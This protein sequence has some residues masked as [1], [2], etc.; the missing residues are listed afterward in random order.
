MSVQTPS[1]SGIFPILLRHKLTILLSGTVLAGIAFGLSQTLPLNYT[2]EGSLIVDSRVI[3]ASD[4]QSNSAVVND[5]LT[6]VDVLLSVGLIRHS[7]QDLDLTHTPGIVATMRLPPPIARFVGA[8]RQSFI[9]LW[10]AINRTTV[11]DSKD[12]QLVTYIQKHLSV[13]AGTGGKK[14]NDNDKNSSVI[15]IK[16]TGGS[17]DA[18]ATV[19]NAL[20]STYLARVHQARDEQIAKVDKWIADQ[21]KEH[22][23]AISAAE[24]QVLQ[25]TQQYNMAEVQGS[26]TPALELSRNQ[27]QLAVLRQEL[28]RQQAALDTISSGGTAV[29]GAQETLESKTIQNLKD[30]EARIIEQISFLTPLDP[31]RGHLQSELSGIQSMIAEQNRLIVASLRRAVQVTQSRVTV[32]EAAIHEDTVKAQ[33]AAVRAATLKQLVNGLEAQRQVYITFLTQADRAQFAAEQDSAAHMLFPAAPPLRPDRSASA[34]ALVL[35]FLGGCLGASG[36]LVAQAY[37]RPRINSAEEMELATGLPVFGTLPDFKQARGDIMALPDIMALSMVTETFRAMWV[38]M[39]SPQ[40]GQGGM[41]IVVTSSDAEEGKTT[42]AMTLAQ[43]FAADGF[44][45]LL[46]DAD[47]RRPRL[48][49]LLNLPTDRS[50]K[51]VI[52]NSAALAQATVPLANGLDCLLS[53]GKAGN[54]IKVLLSDQFLQLITLCREQYDFV[55]L[56]SP[57]AMRVTDPILLAKLVQHIVFV[58]RAGRTPNVLAGEATKRFSEEDRAKM[59][60]LLTRVREADMRFGY[61]GYGHQT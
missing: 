15:S 51:S 17:P 6:E 43:R 58:A 32:L 3:A 18:A 34:L 39:R 5:V 35:G 19:V 52:A 30:M 25:F 56:D 13:A 45:V 8:A 22:Q 9:N 24:Q 40:T 41:A 21:T 7:I 1:V 28:A 10:H 20:V 33:E 44:R 50:L 37:F 46:V 23:L 47:L 16:F 11:S 4:G 49:K 61:S 55:I 53:S 31:R 26:L 36:V 2:S 60:T 59:L 29:P 12:D 54:P 38:A 14:L 42:V 27:D 48:A 57:P